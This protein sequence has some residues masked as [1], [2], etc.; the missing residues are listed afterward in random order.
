VVVVVDCNVSDCEFINE[1]GWVS[2]LAFLFT[3]KTR[4]LFIF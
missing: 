2:L 4:T 3:V 1:Q